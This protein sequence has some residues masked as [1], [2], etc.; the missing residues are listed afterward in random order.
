[1]TREFD[2]PRELVWKAWTEPERVKDWW[3]PK[4]YT[5]PACNIDLRAG[6]QYLYC[7]RS[8]EGQDYWSTGVYRDIVEEERIDYTNSFADEN[9]NVVPATHY[10]MSV[11][12]PLEMQMTVTFAALEGKTRITLRH[13]SLPSGVMI[14]LAQAGWNESFDKLAEVLQ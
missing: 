11:N 13:A 4:Y 5:A 7:M 3:G 1:M 14:E 12:F 9:G 2:A 6:G 10:G 8:P